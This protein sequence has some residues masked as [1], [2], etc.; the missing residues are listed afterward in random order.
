MAIESAFKNSKIDYRYTD[1]ICDR[2][3]KTKQG[4]SDSRDQYKIRF[5]WRVLGK[6]SF[7]KKKDKNS[8]DE[9]VWPVHASC[10]HAC[11][12]DI[13]KRQYGN[14]SKA[15]RV[16]ESQMLNMTLRD[17]KLNKWVRNHKIRRSKGANI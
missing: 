4:E 5:V 8:K 14:I 11:T 13:H 9:S 12:L 1:M 2:N 7:I 17:R 6:L 10:L 15:E 3:S 16:M